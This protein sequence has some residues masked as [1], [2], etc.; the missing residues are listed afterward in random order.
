[1]AIQTIGQAQLNRYVLR[2]RL[3]GIFPG[4]AEDADIQRIRVVIAAVRLKPN[5][6]CAIPDPP[7]CRDKVLRTCSAELMTLFVPTLAVGPDAHPMMI[8]RN[9]LARACKKL[10][11]DNPVFNCRQVRVT[12]QE[13]V[14]R[15]A[16]NPERS[17]LSDGKG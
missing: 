11:P 2:Q 17:S 4:V 1:M 12:R 14:P 5:G 10:S 9:P 16:S 8:P 13:M 15:E 7:L 3:D 6:L